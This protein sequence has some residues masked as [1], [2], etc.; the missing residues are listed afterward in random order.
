MPNSLAAEKEVLQKSIEILR[1][2]VHGKEKCQHVK[3]CAS[4]CAADEAA[5]CGPAREAAYSA[6]TAPG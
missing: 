1:N 2:F 5:G 4:D 3:D 6:A